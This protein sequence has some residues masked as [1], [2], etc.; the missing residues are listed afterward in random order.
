MGSALDLYA[1]AFVARFGRIFAEDDGVPWEITT[2][3]LREWLDEL[4]LG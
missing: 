3:E 4:R 1:Q 2:A